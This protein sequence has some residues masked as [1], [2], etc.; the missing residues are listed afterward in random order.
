MFT[1][2]GQAEPL[3]CFPASFIWFAFLLFQFNNYMLAFYLYR[4][5]CFVRYDVC[6]DAPPLCPLFLRVHCGLSQAVILGWRLFSTPYPPLSP[7]THTSCCPHK[8]KLV[9]LKMR[10]TTNSFAMLN[11]GG[12]RLATKASSALTRRQMSWASAA[13]CSKHTPVLWWRGSFLIFSM[14]ERLLV[15]PFIPVS[16]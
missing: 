15:S 11:R 16:P 13:P 7:R 4:Q 3:F 5:P 9:K 8:R 12:I 6:L 1:A 10:F 2:R 14:S